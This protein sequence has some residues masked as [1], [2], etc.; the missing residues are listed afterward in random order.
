MDFKGK[1][2][3]IPEKSLTAGI[4]ENFYINRNPLAVGFYC[5]KLLTSVFE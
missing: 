5:I 2:F 3:I 4:L 1:K